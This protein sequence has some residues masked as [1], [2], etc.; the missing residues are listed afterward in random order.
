MKD[1]AIYGA[2]GFGREVACLLRKINEKTPTWNFIGFFD[3]G[4]ELGVSNEYGTILGGINELNAI[5]K[6]LAIILA[7]GTPE[8]VKKLVNA[9]NSPL[10][11]FPNIFSPDVTFLDE[12]NIA[13]GRGNIVCM[14]CLFSCNVKIGSFNIF[15][16]FTTVGH[17]VRMA[18]YNSLMP[19]V[20]VSGEVEIGSNNFFGVSSVVLQQ[21]KI[22]NETVVGA[23]SV[24]IRKTK[25]G[26]TYIG[27]PALIVKY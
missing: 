3:D 2:G 10:V 19:A 25:N 27:N 1:I 7:I 24:V 11:E 12:N 22:G 14:G 6:P 17:D 23:N 4:K 9:I 16:N 13:F 26:N 8:I 15:N 5:T 18:D 20:R 21:I